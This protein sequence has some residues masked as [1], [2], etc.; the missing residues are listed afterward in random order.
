[1]ASNYTTNYELPLWEPQDS[2][3][4]TEFNDANQ[5]ID[6][7]LAA[8]SAERIY[9]GSYT[10]D[11]TTGMRTIPLPFTPKV[12]IV[13]GQKPAGDKSYSIFT[14]AFGTFCHQF[15]GSGNSVSGNISIV[16][17]GFQVQGSYHNDSGMVQ[18]Y[19]AF[20]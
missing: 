1:M 19:I 20:R 9:V 7:A 12:V 6:T 8:A 4:R 14:V 11:G 5:K 10:G 17:N 13:S 15:Y 3:L 2:F 16:E 18:R